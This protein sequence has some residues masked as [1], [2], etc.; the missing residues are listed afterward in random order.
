M[1]DNKNITNDYSLVDSPK[2]KLTD[3]ENDN[4]TNLQNN[5]LIK[6]LTDSE[7]TDLT[8]S[9]FTNLSDSEFTNLINSGHMF[10]TDYEYNWYNEQNKIP[11]FIS[12]FEENSFLKEL[13][14]KI[15]NLE[16]QLEW[17]DIYN[18]LDKYI[19]QVLEYDK[20]SL[21]DKKSNS[22]NSFFENDY[23]ENLS[24]N[25][26]NNSIFYQLDSFFLECCRKKFFN[27]CD[28]IF[29]RIYQCEFSIDICKKMIENYGF[30][31]SIGYDEN[32]HSWINYVFHN[33]F[34]NCNLDEKNELVNLLIE[35]FVIL[36][37][38]F[39]IFLEY[40][41]SSTKNFSTFFLKNILGCINN[42]CDEYSFFKLLK[43]INLSKNDIFKDKQNVKFSLVF[44]FYKVY[45][46]Q[47]S[48]GDWI[49]LFKNELFIEHVNMCILLDMLFI[50][51]PNYFIENL[52]EFYEYDS[53][54]YKI[55]KYYST[56]PT[57]KH[58]IKK[59]FYDICLSE[60][61]DIISLS[62]KIDIIFII[63]KCCKQ[64]IFL[65]D[66]IGNE[67]TSLDL[68][69]NIY[70]NIKEQGVYVLDNTDK[71]NVIDKLYYIFDN[72]DDPFGK[73]PIY[74]VNTFNKLLLMSCTTLDTID[75]LTNYFINNYDHIINFFLEDN[76]PNIFLSTV[77][78]TLFKRYP[79]L[80][81]SL[82]FSHYFYIISNKYVDNVSD[83]YV[84]NVSDK[85]VDNVSDKYVDN[86]SNKYVDNLYISS[87]KLERMCKL[88]YIPVELSKH[89][90]INLEDYFNIAVKYNL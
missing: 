59:K 8:E 80:L 60:T 45:R 23:N 87:E 73:Y 40:Y 5:S 12:L 84:D 22:F 36:H 61:Q 55:F 30:S 7:F 16:N 14:L 52:I 57:L 53:F 54:L 6:N 88:L 41:L 29:R 3:S 90:Q 46:Y 47:F 35:N 69:I 48:T 77:R 11:G 43:H 63:Y 66:Y 34:L 56:D 28:F 1:M 89:I 9:E 82:K 68:I 76:V 4:L 75:E 13:I 58:M 49:T 85:Y 19:L 37:K 81:F 67:M 74:N 42:F 64:H 24:D 50:D 70:Q 65:F 21:K 18:S 32:I 10:L 83:K 72:F 71:F 17:I 26:C 86:V 78:D 51:N 62:K 15:Q 38:Y 31:E 33:H 20:D 25:S 44:I 79:E 27:I 2:T 39:Y